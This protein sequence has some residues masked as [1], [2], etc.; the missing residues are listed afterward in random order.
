MQYL[1]PNPTHSENSR[2]YKNTCT[3]S[4]IHGVIPPSHIMNPL[5]FRTVVGQWFLCSFHFPPFLVEMS[6]G[7][8]LCPSSQ[9]IVVCWG[10]V[11]FLLSFIC[12]QKMYIPNYTPGASSSLI[13]IRTMRFWALNLCY[14]GTRLWGTLVRSEYVLYMIGIWITVDQRADYCRYTLEVVPGVYTFLKFP[15]LECGK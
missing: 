8:F 4:C 10:W 2:K 14:N 9:G 6:I 15:P 11:T 12:P 5:D 3:Y 1:Y 13:L 7:A